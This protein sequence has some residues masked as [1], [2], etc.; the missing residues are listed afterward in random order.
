M[1]KHTSYSRRAAFE[2]AHAFIS[3]REGRKLDP[4]SAARERRHVR[5]ERDNAR[6]AALFG[7]EVI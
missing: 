6:W 1:A 7:S 4:E 2:E 5:R 3:A